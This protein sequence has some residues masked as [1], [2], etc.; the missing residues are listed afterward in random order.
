MDKNEKIRTL[1]DLEEAI[2]VLSNIELVK[3]DKY[4]EAFDII[5]DAIRKYI[6]QEDD[7]DIKRAVS[8]YSPLLNKDYTSARNSIKNAISMIQNQ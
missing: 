8:V 5:V 7:Y 3:K 2:R 1:E 6:D 4:S